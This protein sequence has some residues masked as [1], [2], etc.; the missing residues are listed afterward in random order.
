LKKV[1]WQPKQGCQK[2]LSIS[3]W[4][5]YFQAKVYADGSAGKSIAQQQSRGT[6]RDAVCRLF[7]NLY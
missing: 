7:V 1:F 5:E 6:P 4:L 2:T 3:T